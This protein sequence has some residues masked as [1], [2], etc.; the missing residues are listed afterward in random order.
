M[1]LKAGE[2]AK[3]QRALTQANHA[4]EM[5]EMEAAARD[6]QLR[7]QKTVMEFQEAARAA[8]EEA[9]AQLEAAKAVPCT[10]HPKL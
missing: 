7:A 9:T 3:A 8:G 10:L 5:A 1:N 6:A 4:A 2:E